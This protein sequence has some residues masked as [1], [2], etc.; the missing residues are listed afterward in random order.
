MITTIL[1]CEIKY[2]NRDMLW[3][4]LMSIGI[5]GLFLKAIQSL[6]DFY[7]PQYSETRSFTYG[8]GLNV[9]MYKLTKIPLNISLDFTSLPQISYS[10]KNRKLDNFTNTTLRLNW[11]I[12]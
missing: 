5:H 10:K 12:I 6:Y 3:R 7:L 9:P 8:F 11:I 2:V 1:L 4:K